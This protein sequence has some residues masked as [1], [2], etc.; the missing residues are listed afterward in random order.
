MLFLMHLLLSSI[1]DGTT[2][3]LKLGV[4]FLL[5]FIDAAAGM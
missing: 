5:S 1:K 3:E 4:T 2:K